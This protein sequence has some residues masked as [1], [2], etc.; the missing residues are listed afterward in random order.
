MII[1]I[2]SDLHLDFY[3]KSSLIDH[4][5]VISFFEPILT[6]K[7]TRQIGDILIVAGDL[8]HYNTQNLT[9]L[10]ILQSEFYD[11][12]ICVLGNHDYYLVSYEE[13]YSFKDK[14]VK[15]VEQLRNMINKE[16][17][18]YCL[19]GNSVEINGIRFAGCDSWYDDSYT[20]AY[21]PELSKNDTRALW[22]KNLNDSRL[23][24]GINHFDDITAI[25][26]E[27]LEKIYQKCDVMITHVNPSYKE[28]HIAPQYHH[29]PINTFF[30]F[31]GSPFYQKGSMKFWVFGHTH[32]A[33][34]YELGET[35][36]LCNPL[37][38][39]SESNFGNN[40]TMKSFAI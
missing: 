29:S 21:F 25:E 36:F 16:A 20:K 24:Y 23:I 34:E 1:D 11:H 15:R 32:D 22:K 7:G 13:R 17:N 19:N 6:D 38:Y 31:D 8:G 4:G 28:E 39:P 33:I 18:L 3:F 40:I 26:M 12:I 2:L 35:L 9:V 27:K 10:K 30:T 5:H 37:G 14:S